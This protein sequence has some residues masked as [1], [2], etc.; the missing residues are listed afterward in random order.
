VRAA[1]NVTH[2]SINRLGLP[3]PMVLP[4]RRTRQLDR[5]LL[6]KHDFRTRVPSANCDDE[7]EHHT[8]T[9][10]FP[11]SRRFRTGMPYREV[12]RCALN[13]FG[14]TLISGYSPSSRNT[15]RFFFPKR[16]AGTW[17]M[18][19]RVFESH[20]HLEVLQSSPLAIDSR[21]RRGWIPSQKTAQIP[22]C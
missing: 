9:R 14:Y 15:A 18:F 3:Q 2:L 10:H 12:K 19:L 17:N 16:A 4:N 6:S 11:Y 21:S 22:C 20:F 8:H 5:S 13:T 7:D 1:T